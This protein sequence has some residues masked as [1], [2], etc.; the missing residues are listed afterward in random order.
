MALLQA[1]P[2]LVFLVWVSALALALVLA[3]V[4]V[5]VWVVAVLPPKSHPVDWASCR[6]GRFRYL[7]AGHKTLVAPEETE[8]RVSSS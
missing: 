7:G 4:L 5:L 3:L 1:V 2:L 8:R 6:V